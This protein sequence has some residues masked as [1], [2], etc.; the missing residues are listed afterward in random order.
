MH[1]QKYKNKI[2]FNFLKIFVLAVVTSIAFIIEIASISIVFK[3]FIDDNAK[4]L[5]P[6]TKFDLN[7]DKGSIPFIILLAAIIRIAVLYIVTKEIYKTGIILSNLLF[8]RVYRSSYRINQ[9]GTILNLFTNNLNNTINN[10]LYPTISIVSGF[11]SLLTVSLFLILN[12]NLKFEVIFSLVIAFFIFSSI[13]LI[14]NSKLRKT[15]NRIKNRL[16]SITNY[17]NTILNEYYEYKAVL[18]EKTVKRKVEMDFTTLRNDQANLN[19]IGQAPRILIDSFIYMIIA[20]FALSSVLVEFGQ[21]IMLLVIGQRL[22]PLFNQIY[23]SFINILGHLPQLKEIQKYILESS[24]MN[25]QSHPLIPES[26]KILLKKNKFHWYLG[27]INLEIE[28][29]N[30]IRLPNRGLVLVKGPSGSGKSVFFREI[31]GIGIQTNF[32][33]KKK[34]LYLNQ[35]SDFSN[36]TLDEFFSFSDLVKYKEMNEIKSLLFSQNEI[37]DIFNRNNKSNSNL[38]FSPGQIQRLRLY[39]LL[40]QKYDILILDEPTSAVDQGRIL[41]IQNL[42][43]KLSVNS[44]IIVISHETFLE[45]D[46]D[47]MLEVKGSKLREIK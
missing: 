17:L 43:K 22:M 2:I 28:V 18:T 29:E 14:C 13:I 8:D 10:I 30:D 41:S 16:I 35:V 40:C 34:V 37:N 39:R 5:I 15:S 32:A 20:I 36:V 9:R 33:I 45:K 3:L 11:I 46:F 19:I 6:V 42:I 44:L 25:S 26:D 24:K 27:E 38:N 47:L 7:L 31:F 4:T 23:R 12:L 21:V 1:T